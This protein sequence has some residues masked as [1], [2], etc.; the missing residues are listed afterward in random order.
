MRV[1]LLP[2]DYSL[3]AM[4]HGVYLLRDGVKLLV[5]N[6]ESTTF[7][8]LASPTDG[9]GNLLA[10]ETGVAEHILTDI[11]RDRKLG[12]V[13]LRALSAGFVRVKIYHDRRLG[14]VPPSNANGWSSCAGI[15]A[16]D[17]FIFSHLD[18]VKF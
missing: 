11:G 9:V 10:R 8:V 15:V 1:L 17:A 6:R 4:L 3:N 5:L 18:L 14:V 7:L 16:E 12:L 2:R 13:T